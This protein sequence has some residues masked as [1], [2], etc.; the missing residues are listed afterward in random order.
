MTTFLHGGAFPVNNVINSIGITSLGLACCL[1]D[2]TDELKKK[3]SE[4]I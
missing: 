2:H 1:K 4:L 3:N